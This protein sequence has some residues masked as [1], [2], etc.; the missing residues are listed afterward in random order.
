MYCGGLKNVCIHVH[1]LEYIHSSNTI[2]SFHAVQ[3]WAEW[4]DR[5]ISL[6][7]RVA[8][9]PRHIQPH[10]VLETVVFVPL[11]ISITRRH[12]LL[13]LPFARLPCEYV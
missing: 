9:M 13:L 8:Q 2:S 3:V 7:F 12:P 10:N 6:A 4:V 1:K 5:F 11:K